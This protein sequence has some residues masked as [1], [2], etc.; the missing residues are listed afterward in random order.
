[1]VRV[2]HITGDGTSSLYQLCALQADNVFPIQ[3]TSDAQDGQ[4]N[5]PDS[6]QSLQVTGSGT[7]TDKLG[8][9]DTVALPFSISDSVNSISLQNLIPSAN[10]MVVTVNFS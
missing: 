9:G 1:M 6:V 8:D 2:A 5:W 4:A 3:Y 7:L 10:A